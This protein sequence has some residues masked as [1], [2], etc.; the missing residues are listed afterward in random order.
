MEG[1]AETLMTSDVGGKQVAGDGQTLA[2]AI[3]LK[4]TD[5]PEDVEWASTPWEP[6]PEGEAALR[7]CAGLPPETD[8][9]RADSPG[10]YEAPAMKAVTM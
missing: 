9:P 5:L 2:D 3:V 6:D 10:G 4:E 8:S 7:R 1:G